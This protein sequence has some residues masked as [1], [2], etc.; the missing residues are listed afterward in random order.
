M[1][2]EKFIIYQMLPRIF[3]NSKVNGGNGKFKDITDEVL[4]EIKKL[5]V[6]YIWYTG[7]I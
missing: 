2:N 6:S 7:I 5:N 1:K 4:S 3:G